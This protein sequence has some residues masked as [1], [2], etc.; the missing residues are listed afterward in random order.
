MNMND[1][2]SLV[3]AITAVA[4]IG[5][6][7]WVVISRP[8]SKITVEVVSTTPT[9]IVDEP[10]DVSIRPAGGWDTSTTQPA[11][12]PTL[13][14]R[15]ETYAVDA[16]EQNEGAWVDSLSELDLVIYGRDV[17]DEFDRGRWFWDMYE[18]RL[19]VIV[20]QGWTSQVD[21]NALKWMMAD[22]VRT[23]CEDRVDRYLPTE[24]LVPDYL[25]PGESD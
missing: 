11:P 8:P 13:S 15:A 2:W 12:P 9:T 18:K 25:L 10:T 5:L 17:C 21:A 24:F 20:S 16:R 6:V 3:A 22:G 23:F 14:Q 19:A 4:V 7:T 1:F